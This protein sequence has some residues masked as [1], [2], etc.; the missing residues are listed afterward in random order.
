M[1]RWN[2]TWQSSAGSRI[3]VQGLLRYTSVRDDI[4]LYLEVL[5]NRFQTSVQLWNLLRRV[6]FV[7]ISDRTVQRRMHKSGMTPRRPATGPLPI[8]YQVL[9]LSFIQT[10]ENLIMAQW[11]NWWVWVR[12]HQRVWRHPGKHFD[13]CKIPP[14]VPFWGSSVPVW[15]A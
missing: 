14:R 8:R 13:P 15:P 10:Y 6:R 12:T 5:Q 1:R 9:L 3:Q 4:F 11:S 2:D 7:P